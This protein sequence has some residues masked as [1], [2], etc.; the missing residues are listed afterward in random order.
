LKHR[1]RLIN[2]DGDSV[3]SASPGAFGGHR[4]TKIYGRLDC[5]SARRWIARGHYVQH[6]VFFADEATARSA[7]YRPCAV[8]LPDAYAAGKRGASET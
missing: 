3:A 5:T 6:R 1:Y 4:R 2:A 7:G 8:C